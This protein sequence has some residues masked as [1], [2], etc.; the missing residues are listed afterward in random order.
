MKTLENMRTPRYSIY[1]NKI[2]CGIL[3]ISTEWK[4]NMD[5]SWFLCGILVISDVLSI[6]YFIII[7]QL[8]QFTTIDENRLFSQLLFFIR[9]VYIV[10]CKY[11]NLLQ[12]LCD[13]T[14][15]MSHKF[16]AWYHYIYKLKIKSMRSKYI[17]TMQYKLWM[18]YF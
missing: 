3:Y 6:I 1:Q 15:V 16:Y 5:N 17:Y 11:T 7:L 2:L 4:L 10:L 13:I 12:K 14:M 9:A 18:N 8:T